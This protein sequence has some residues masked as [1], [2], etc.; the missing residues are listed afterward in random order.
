MCSARSFE[1]AFY[2]IVG[3]W[4]AARSIK[5]FNW[6]QIVACLIL[7]FIGSYFWRINTGEMFFENNK[8]LPYLVISI[9]ATWSFYSLFLKL[10]DMKNVFTNALSFIGN[11]TIT[12]LTWHMLVFKLVSLIII[13]IYK[14]PIESLSEFP[15]IHEFSKQGWWALYV[16]VALTA[17]SGIAYLNKWISKSWLKL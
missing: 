7:T 1:V 2:I 8:Y 12:I 15:V 4:F 16:V 6:W 11:N 14:L 5:P 17:C 3:H 9:L 10:G 13:K